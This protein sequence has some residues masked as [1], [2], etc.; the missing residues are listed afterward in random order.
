MG[1]ALVAG[2]VLWVLGGVGVAGAVEADA[3]GEG[4]VQ[5]FGGTFW[6]EGPAEI[7]VRVGIVFEV[8]E[9]AV[10]VDVAF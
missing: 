9:V 8:E 7:E 3:A 1:L 2:P 10:R 4:C 6:G 5:G